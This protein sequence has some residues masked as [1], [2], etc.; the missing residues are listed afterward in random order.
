LSVPMSVQSDENYCRE[1]GRRFKDPRLVVTSLILIVVL[2]AAVVEAIYF[3]TLLQEYTAQLHEYERKVAS[4]ESRVQ[5]LE[6]DQ[7][8]LKNEK[9]QLS[10]ELSHYRLKRP[11]YYELLDFLAND[12]TSEHVYRKG[13]YVCM[14][15]A[16]DLKANAIQQGWNISFVSINFDDPTGGGGHAC[17]GAY[18]ADGSWVWIEPQ[19][20]RIYRDSVESYLESFFGV[21]WVQVEEIVVVW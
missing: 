6:S 10:K 7:T 14:N 9:M 19:T 12:G 4:L 18:L 5:D 2:G 13:S 15:F 1:C 8:R 21:S 3:Q 16:W 11:T 17:N 20:D